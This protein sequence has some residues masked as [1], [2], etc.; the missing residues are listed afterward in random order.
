MFAARQGF[1]SSQGPAPVTNARRAGTASTN[2]SVTWTASGA[3]TSTSQYKF[4]TASEYCASG[5]DE[6]YSAGGTTFMNYGTSDFTIEWLMYIPSF[7]GHCQSCDLLSNN[8]SNGFGIRLAQS[9]NNNGLSSA[10]P[11]YIN[12]FARQQADLDYWDIG[13]NWVAGQWH[14]CV[15]QRKSATMTF[16]LNGT[17]AS[18]GGSGGGSRNF[19]SA[20]AGSNVLIGSAEGSNGAGPIYIDEICFSNTYRYTDITTSIPVPTAAFTVD[21]YTTQLLHMDGSNGGTTFTNATS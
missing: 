21:S 13:G 20:S 3:V 16:W 10:S 6:I 17:L 7:S 5:T 1:F 8:L 18:H 11:R 15:M 14:F 19:A 2:S 9:Y 4:G 12:I